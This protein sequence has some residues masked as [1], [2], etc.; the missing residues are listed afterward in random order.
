LNQ[1][2]SSIDEGTVTLPLKLHIKCAYATIDGNNRSW[3]L[4]SKNDFEIGKDIKFSC[5]ASGEVE[6]TQKELNNLRLSV[7]SPR[8]KIKLT[9]FDKNR[10]VLT[11]VNIER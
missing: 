10:D 8:F 4:Y 6:V 3:K 1:L 7:D 2:Q 5:D 9:G 11:K